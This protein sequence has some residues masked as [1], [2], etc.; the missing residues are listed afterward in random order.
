MQL[1]MS[2]ASILCLLQQKELKVPMIIPYDIGKSVA[3]YHIS[4]LN[5][6]KCS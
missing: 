4:S 5:W 6:A 1:C 3:K 2:E